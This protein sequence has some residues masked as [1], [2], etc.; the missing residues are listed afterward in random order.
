MLKGLPHAAVE[1]AV[2]DAYRTV[3]LDGN[4]EVTAPALAA[5]IERT[6]QR[7]W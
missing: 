6:R 7:P 4:R 5:A 2:W 3:L 1:F